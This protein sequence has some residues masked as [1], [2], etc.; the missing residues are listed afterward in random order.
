MNIFDVIHAK[1]S[2]DAIIGSIRLSL[3]DL[4]EKYQHKKD[5]ISNLEKYE[6]WMLEAEILLVL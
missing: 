6:V 3:K 5:L 2:L 4:R 1:T